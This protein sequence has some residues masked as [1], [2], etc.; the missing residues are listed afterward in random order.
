[1][2][3]A[4]GFR[5]APQRLALRWRPIL[6]VFVALGVAIKRPLEIAKGN[7]ETGPAVDKPKLENVVLE[8]RPAAVTERAGHRDALA[9]ELGRSEGRIAV[10]LAQNLV[11]IA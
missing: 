3:C 10:G 4:S 2:R 7:D 5:F 6:H 9:G 1:M 8:E 11:E